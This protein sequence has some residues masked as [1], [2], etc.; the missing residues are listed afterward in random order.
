[1]KT[2]KISTLIQW[3]SAFAQQSSEALGSIWAFAATLAIILIWFIGGCFI[4][5][6]DTYQIVINTLSTLTT[7]IFVVIIQHTQNRHE[8]AL[9]RKL[10]EL[11]RSI[12]KADNR[13]I[14]L[15]KQPPSA[16]PPEAG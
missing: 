2:S 8:A 1:M 5:F 12:D 9:H 4:G 7:S 3:F 13:L 14:G 15:E 16:C 10:D 11:I 6:T